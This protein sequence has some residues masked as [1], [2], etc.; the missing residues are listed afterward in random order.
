MFSDEPNG[1]AWFSSA[2]GKGH[3]STFLEFDCRCT[4]KNR[5]CR[6]SAENPSLKGF[7]SPGEY[8]LA[9]SI[10]W[11]SKMKIKLD[12][13]LMTVLA[14]VFLSFMSLGSLGEVTKAEGAEDP[15]EGFTVPGKG[16]FAELGWAEA[17][18]AA[19]EKLSRE[20]AFTDWK[21]VDWSALCGRFLPLIRKAEENHDEKAYYRALHGFL[22]SIRDGHVS[23]TATDLAIP[24]S[25]GRERLGGGYGLAVAETDAHRSVV[26]A[27][28][29]NGPAS[30]AG[31]LPGAEV[32]SWGGLPVNEAIGRIDIGEVPYRAL[33]G[34]VSPNVESSIATAG[35]YRLEQARLLVRAPVNTKVEV[36]FRNPGSTESRR[37]FLVAEEDQGKTY[38][39][40]NFAVRPD[41]SDKVDFR[42]LPEGYG[43]LRLRAFADLNDLSVYPETI[44]QQIREALC[45]FV[46]A[47]VPGV[48]VDL[49][50]NYGGFDQLAADLCGF[51]T[52]S[53]TFFESQVMYDQRNGTFL[54]LGDL[55][56]TPQEPYFAGPVAVL[57]NPGTKSSGEG[58][59]AFFSKRTSSGVVGFHG[60]NG[61]FGLAGG[62]ILLPGGYTIKYPY[63]RSLGMDGQI[64]LDSRGGAGGVSPQ[65]RVPKTVRNILA[66]ASGRDVE[67]E[68][69]ID[70][71]KAQGNSRN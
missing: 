38:P 6:P 67:L 68:Y 44:Y 35:H 13:I 14:V 54:N 19:S 69:A 24:L 9:K 58:P 29:P 63:G 30:R 47:G 4:I 5:T 55:Y 10:S 12:G 45:T 52:P 64:Q 71:L 56:V 7:L 21:Q 43:Y 15:R 60:T 27:V 20:Y 8:S 31:I 36:I 26:A 59:A 1:G 62:E 16:N 23:L 11:R 33:S 17:F 41:F 66:Y 70:F 50:G 61:S 37:V 42:I 46:A 53:E 3:P 39:L 51:F 22:F 57:V 48:I 32:E 40:L 65:I 25:I 2:T 34:E 28:L 18:R 49:R